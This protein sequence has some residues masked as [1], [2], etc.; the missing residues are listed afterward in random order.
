MM[1]I[2]KEKSPHFLTITQIRHLALIFMLLFY[3]WTLWFWRISHFQAFGEIWDFAQYSVHTCIAG[4]CIVTI[5][6]DVCV[7]GV[8]NV[9]GVRQHNTQ[10]TNYCSVTVRQSE[11][12][13]KI[14]S[15][16]I[17][18]TP[19]L[20]LPQYHVKEHGHCAKSTGGWLQL[21]C[22]HAYK[23]TLSLS[24]CTSM[25]Y[26]SWSHTYRTRSIDH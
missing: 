10:I 18:S 21:N 3:W 15:R 6:A 8:R 12:N 26:N 22:K 11:E 4:L 20:V 16:M 17:C 9:S 25:T 23:Y 24:T 2:K 14:A 5:S 19:V 7:G 13:E 1:M